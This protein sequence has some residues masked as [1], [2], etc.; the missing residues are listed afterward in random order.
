LS[1]TFASKPG[2]VV[3]DGYHQ[4]K[5]PRALINGFPLNQLW[6]Q[7]KRLFLKESGAPRNNQEI[8][9]KIYSQEILL[10]ST[11][12]PNSHLAVFLF[13]ALTFSID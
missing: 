2:Y 4:N 10:T 8:D 12:I 6:L 11:N 13:Q 9:I 5:Q 1:D 3:L 7:Q